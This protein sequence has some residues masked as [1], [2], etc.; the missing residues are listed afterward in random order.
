MSDY[1]YILL[2]P[3]KGYSR[4]SFFRKRPTPAPPRG[5]E[6][7]YPWQVCAI[8]L[9]GRGYYRAAGLPPFRGDR[10][11]AFF[12]ATIGG[13]WA[14]PLLGGPRGAVGIE[15]GG[16]LLLLRL[17]SCP[18]LFREVG[19]FAFE[20]ERSTLHELLP[21]VTATARVL[22]FEVVTALVFACCAT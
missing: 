6:N 16:F 9:V 22:L 8:S 17:S 15:E 3:L 18:S 1:R 19:L 14:S 12:G 20:L 11:G 2:S 10:G 7:Q 13:C 21:V 4:L 5:G